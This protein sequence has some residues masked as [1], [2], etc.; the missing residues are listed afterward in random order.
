M[1]LRLLILPVLALL[2]ASCGGPAAPTA[3]APAV[4]ATSESAPSPTPGLLIVTRDAASLT[5]EPVGA[6]P[7]AAA[8]TLVASETEDPNAGKPFD[9]IQM[10]RIGS[11]SDETPEKIDIVINADGSYTRS[12]T[13]GVLTPDRVQALTDM[14]DKV[15][16]FGLQGNMVGAATGTGVYQYALT[17]TRAGASRTIVSTDGYMPQEYVQ[18]VGAVFAVGLRP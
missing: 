9:S 16:F 8:G 4:E 15:N 1:R 12:G 3:T 18:L 13:S 10:S 6:L 7:I 5:E 11:G 17:I 14:I 2:L